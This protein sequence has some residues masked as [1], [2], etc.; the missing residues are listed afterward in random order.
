MA[1]TKKAPKKL[2]SQSATT[3]DKE[4]ADKLIK[5]GYEDGLESGQQQV[6]AAMVNFFQQRMNTYFELRQDEMAK[7]CREVLSLIKPNL[8]QK[9]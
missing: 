6:Y 8:K 7:E 9:P 3:Y 5:K 2:K 1:V 4:Y